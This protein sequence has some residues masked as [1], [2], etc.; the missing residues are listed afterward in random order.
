L[1]P[2]KALTKENLEEFMKML[3]FGQLGEGAKFDTR[4]QGLGLDC[5]VGDVQNTLLKAPK[6]GNGRLI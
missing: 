2:K 3:E 6:V 5:L 4:I 1:D